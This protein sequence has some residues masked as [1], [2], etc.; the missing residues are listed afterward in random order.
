[1]KKKG[2]L[3]LGVPVA[4]FLGIMLLV[5]L[6]VGTMNHKTEDTT[7]TVQ[8]GSAKGLSKKVTRFKKP[9]SEE[10]EKQKVGKEWTDLILAHVE[11]ETHGDAE[12]YPD[13]F[14]AG[15]SVNGKMN[16]LNT[17]DSIHYGVKAF[18]KTLDQVK[19]IT[20]H[21]PKPTSEADVNI[22]TVLYNAPAFGPWL[23][24]KHGGK[25][26]VEAND[27]FYANVMPSF[28]AGPGD[29]KYYQHVLNYYDPHTGK[30]TTGDSEKDYGGDWTNPLPNTSLAESSFQGGQLFGKRSGGEF[31]QNGFHSGLDFGSNDHAGSKVVASHAGKVTFCGDPHVPDLGAVIIVIDTGK[32]NTIYQEFATNKSD[33]KVK[34]GDTVKAGQEIATRNTEHLHFGITT[35]DW[36]K[37]LASSFSDNGVYKDPLKFLKGK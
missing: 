19:D 15:E 17:E 18:A 22:S 23:K 11:V 7:S 10:L 30:A 1:M 24:K 34:K 6:M 2:L 35:Q 16:S 31:R 36:E 37:A 20:G 29:K 4:M 8:S 26:S 25:W 13:I 14:Q 3:L 12:R 33:A 21:E 32:Y 5:L 27:D 28:G 9:I